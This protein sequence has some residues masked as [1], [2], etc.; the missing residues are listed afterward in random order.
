MPLV[1]AKLSYLA[2]SCDHNI[3]FNRKKNIATVSLFPTFRRLKASKM[4][5]SSP[6]LLISQI[7]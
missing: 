6:S 3:Y 4:F 2:L 7:S 1:S 5:A